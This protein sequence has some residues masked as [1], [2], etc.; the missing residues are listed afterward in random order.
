MVRTFD[1][2]AL[3]RSAGGRRRARTT[4]GVR[5]AGRL[6]RNAARPDDRHRR[7]RDADARARRTGSARSGSAGR[8]S[9]RATGSSRRRREATFRACLKDTGE[10]PFLRTGDLGFLQDGELFVTGRLKDLIIVHGVNYLSAGHRADGAAEPSAAAARLR[11]GVHGRGRTAG[12]QLVVVQE[13][14]RRK[15]CGL[16]ARCSRRSAA[17]W[18]P[19]TTCR[20]TRSC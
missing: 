9:P 11:R 3:A 10:G 16:R 7:S 8:A 2:A 1:A 12:E 20:W 4:K 18:P 15:Q 13:V 19:S 14:E 5:G 6:R 17:R